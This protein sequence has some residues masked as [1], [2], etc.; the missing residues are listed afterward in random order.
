VESGIAGE[1]HHESEI[2]GAGTRK[3]LA[4]FAE[5]LSN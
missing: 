4:D 5:I 1:F 2:G 3:K